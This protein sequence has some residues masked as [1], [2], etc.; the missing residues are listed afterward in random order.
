LHSDQFDV[1]LINFENLIYFHKNFN[2]QK[3]KENIEVTK[4]R[5]NKFSSVR[6]IKNE[7]VDFG[8]DL[9]CLFY[10]LFF[11]LKSKTYHELFEKKILIEQMKLLSYKSK[12]ISTLTRK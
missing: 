8:T 10:V 2:E 1:F 9:E 3:F 5:K 11:C 7:K 4:R 6:L 12:L